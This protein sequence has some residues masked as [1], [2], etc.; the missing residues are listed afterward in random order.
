MSRQEPADCDILAGNTPKEVP[1][2]VAAPGWARGRL[3]KR[4]HSCQNVGVAGLPVRVAGNVTVG[5]CHDMV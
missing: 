2:P 4:P 1:S 3:R 5:G